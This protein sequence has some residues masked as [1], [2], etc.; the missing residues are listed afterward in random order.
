MGLFLK[1][2]SF[3]IFYWLK[4]WFSFFQF[5]FIALIFF[6]TVV[7]G[8]SDWHACCSSQQVVGLGENRVEQLD[9]SLPGISPVPIASPFLADEDYYYFLFFGVL[10]LFANPYVLICRPDETASKCLSFRLR[11]DSPMWSVVL[12]AT[13]PIVYVLIKSQPAQFQQSRLGLG[14]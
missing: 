1:F 5:F 14:E 4:I 9:L 6:W 8:I 7:N 2:S 12:D 13:L 10:S 11:A 3:R